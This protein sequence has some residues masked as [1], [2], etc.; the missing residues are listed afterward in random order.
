MEPKV[1]LDFDRRVPTGLYQIDFAAAECALHVR[2]GNMTGEK[3][4]G[5]E[6][7]LIDMAKSLEG[8]RGI[9]EREMAAL[10]LRFR[11]HQR[12]SRGEDDGQWIQVGDVMR[13][14]SME[15]SQKK[16]DE[17]GE[18]HFVAIESAVL[19]IGLNTVGLITTGLITNG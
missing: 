1:I 16:E 10:L 12:T 6:T 15:H 8:S 14:L 13:P 4:I 2:H 7:K 17:S 11:V 19:E 18:G 3:C 9:A 5:D